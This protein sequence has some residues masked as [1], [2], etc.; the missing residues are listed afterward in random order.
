ML[1]RLRPLLKTKLTDS[2]RGNKWW[3]FRVSEN[4]DTLRGE[5][6]EE[7]L[8]LRAKIDR[9]KKQLDSWAT[10][11]KESHSKWPIFYI[12]SFP[13]SYVLRHFLQVNKRRLSTQM[14]MCCCRG[15]TWTGDFWSEAP[16][17]LQQLALKESMINVQMAQRTCF[18][19]FP[20]V[21][22]WS[23]DWQMDIKIQ[24]QRACWEMIILD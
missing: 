18:F 21:H 19:F 23:T 5:G 7:N 16:F 4:T 3:S 6:E 13:C 8:K 2:F 14:P 20:L 1:A 12:S 15:V 11:T 9:T 24:E 10:E 22:T 17:I